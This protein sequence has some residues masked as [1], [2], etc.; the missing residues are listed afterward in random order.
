MMICG[1]FSLVMI[2]TGSHEDG[3]AR[4]SGVGRSFVTAFTL[5]ELLVVIAIIALL[6]G[7]LLPMLGKAKSKGQQIKC[8]SNYRQLQLGWQMYTDDNDTSLPANETFWGA[9]TDRA[10]YIATAR[11]WIT[12]NA[13]TDPTDSNIRAGVLFQHVG[14]SGIYKCPGDTSTVR[15]QGTMPRLRTVAM[16]I[17]MNH[18]PDPSDR[19]YWHRLSQLPS[20]TSAFVFIDEHENSIDNANLW[21]NHASEDWRW[22][23]F[24]ATR[25]NYGSVLSFADG[26]AEPWKW[27]SPETSRISKSARYESFASGVGVTRGDLDLSRFYEAAQRPKF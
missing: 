23:D 4:R 24:P 18:N 7:M 17:F 10:A 6:A 13:W 26:H 12:G 22:Y 16:N 8:L 5:I 15:D 11:S 9:L 20:P 14:S 25:H 1:M 2:A 27:K 3:T 21:I 19:R